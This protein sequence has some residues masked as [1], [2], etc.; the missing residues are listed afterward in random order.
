MPNIIKNTM[1]PKTQKCPVCESI[2]ELEDNEAELDECPCCGTHIEIGEPKLP[3]KERTINAVMD[4]LDFEKI[5]TV[6]EVL[7]WTWRN[8]GVP[9]I[10]TIK[11]QA[12]DLLEYAWE[13]KCSNGTGGF[14]V[15][16][17]GETDEDYPML[18]ISFQVSWAGPCWVSK[19]DNEMQ[20]A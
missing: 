2:W 20:Y 9:S 11:K 15:E 6:M 14:W 5:H 7:V 3:V 13:H 17:E 1:K 4:Q 12:Y 10:E 16:Y 8:Q 18:K 19:K